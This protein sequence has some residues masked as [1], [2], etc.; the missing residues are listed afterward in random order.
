[1]AFLS[2]RPIILFQLAA[3][4]VG[5]PLPSIPKMH[6][7]NPVC[8]FCLPNCSMKGWKETEMGGKSCSLN[9]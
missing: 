3:A 8:L 1:L 9:G 5:Q 6:R 2:P 7:A 4:A